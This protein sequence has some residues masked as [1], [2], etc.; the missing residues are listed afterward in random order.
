VSTVVLVQSFSPFFTKNDVNSIPSNEI[1]NV[2]ELSNYLWIVS[3]DA[4]FKSN[5]EGFKDYAKILG[6]EFNVLR[7]SSFDGAKTADSAVAACD[8]KIYIH[9]GAHCAMLQGRMAKGI[10]IPKITIKKV[11]ML[12]EKFEELEKK[13][14]SKCVIQSFY[15]VGELVIFTF[16]YSSYSDSYT[17]IEK[18]GTKSG[19]AAI[20]VDLVSWKIEDS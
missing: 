9:S 11:A 14:F 16:R 18:D 6:M 7:I 1:Q 10:I 5:I 19:T 2:N 13:E 20:K 4:V 15:R 3:A 8:I 17:E 12:S